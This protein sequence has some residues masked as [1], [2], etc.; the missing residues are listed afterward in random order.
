MF[1]K[2]YT[3]Y[4]IMAFIML[5]NFVFSQFAETQITYEYN[6]NQIRDDEIY[7]LED[8]TGKIKKY[9]DISNFS[10]DFNDLN[11]SLKIHFIFDN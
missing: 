9:Y 11:I 1:K 3:N 2:N 7:I 10:Y 6:E 5:S 4:A 8:F